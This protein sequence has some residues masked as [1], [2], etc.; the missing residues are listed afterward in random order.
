MSIVSLIKIITKEISYGN[1]SVSQRIR[2]G[3]AGPGR[4]HEMAKRKELPEVFPGADVAKRIDTQDE[5]IGVSSL[6]LPCE[7][8]KCI[9]GI[10]RPRPSDFH[11]GNR[12]TGIFAHRQAN[13]L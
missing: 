12:E 1:G 3:T 5:E 2:V 9:N 10:R 11:S 6:I 7:V 13:H 4:D 8:T